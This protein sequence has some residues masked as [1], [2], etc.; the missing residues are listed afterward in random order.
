MIAT[1]LTL[2]L[3]LVQDPAALVTGVVN[4]GL[5]ATGTLGMGDGGVGKPLVARK[6]LR[7]GETLTR[8]GILVRAKDEGVKLDFPTG[9]ELIVT[10]D[11]KVWLRD[12]SATLSAFHGLTLVLADGERVVIV[13]SPGRDLPL[14]HVAVGTDDR[15]LELWRS[16][17]RVADAAFFAKPRGL[18]LYCLG[19]GTELWQP[20]FRGP[21]LVLD[22]VLASRE[23]SADLPKRKIL[24]LGDVLR[25]SLELLPSRVPRK[26]LDFPEADTIVRELSNGRAVLFPRGEI[27]RP[28]GTVGE[29]VFPLA[30]EFLL[31]VGKLDAQPLLLTLVRGR[32]EIPYLEWSVGPRTLLH[33]T[34]PDGSHWQREIEI[35]SSLPRH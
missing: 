17:T 3:P 10:N 26:H 33:I 15:S 11:A 8:G 35:T 25:D 2:A 29:L 13:P 24:V 31:R 7:D 32:T 21:V 28:E 20:T 6:K 22:R 23:R 18:V 34:K 19:D 9:G 4:D 27:Q 12:G 14:E 16:R 5:V 1:L 30:A